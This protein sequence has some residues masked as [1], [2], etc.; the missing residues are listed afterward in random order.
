M[1]VNLIQLNPQSIAMDNATADKLLVLGSGDAALLYLY[2]LRNGGEYDPAAAERLLHR[3]RSQLDTAMAQL[4]ELGLATGAKLPPAQPPQ[5]QPDQAPEYTSKDILHE[6]NDETS[7]FPDL[8]KE[9]ESVMGKRL[10]TTQTAALLELYDYVGLPSEVLLMMVNWLQARN[11]RRYGTGRRL[12]IA[13]VKR[14]GYQWKDYG[15]DTLDAAEEYIRAADLRESEIGAMMAACGIHGRKP[16]TSEGRYM[17]QWLDW[18]FPPETIAIAYDLTMT[19]QGRMNWSYCNGIVRS[20]HEKNLRT[21]EQVKAERKPAAPR[22][23][24]GKPAQSGK[25]VSPA[26]PA[27]PA[28]NNQAELRRLLQRLNDEN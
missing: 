1:P 10:S 14:T 28:D 5:P 11:R 24:I 20:W 12:T 17:S 21:P 7:R 3:T 27:A 23:Q 4:T 9:V 6:M 13:E 15:Y 18:R 26:K 25:P 2:L 8:L 22:P 16:T 19:N